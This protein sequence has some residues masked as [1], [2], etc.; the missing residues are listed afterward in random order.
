[1]T[2]AMVYSPVG[3]VVGLSQ[4]QGL[5]RGRPR[6]L[7]QHHHAERHRAGH[8][9]WICP[10]HTAPRGRVAT[11][12]SEQSPQRAPQQQKFAPEL[13]AQGRCR[14]L[15]RGLPSLTCCCRSFRELE[16]VRALGVLGSLSALLGWQRAIGVYLLLESLEER[17][18]RGA[19]ASGAVVRASPRDFC[20]DA[21]VD[22]LARVH[23]LLSCA[24]A[25]IVGADQR[26]SLP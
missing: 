13:Q 21:P 19:R 20:R 12:L 10:S 9:R 14:V 17:F 2:A 23:H 15:D 1:M 16:H 26:V 6:V 8:H 22:V 5:R 4:E 7:R 24:S 25:Q 18:S 11:G 3:L